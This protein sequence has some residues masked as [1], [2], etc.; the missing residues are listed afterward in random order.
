[1]ASGKLLEREVKYEPKVTKGWS[2]QFVHPRPKGKGGNNIG[3]VHSD[4]VTAVLW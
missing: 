3:F 1:M 2:M 4:I